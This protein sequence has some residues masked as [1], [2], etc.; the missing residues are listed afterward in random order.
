[1]PTRWLEKCCGGLL[2]WGHFFL[3]GGGGGGG[4][5][6][7]GISISCI[8]LGPKGVPMWLLRDLSLYYIDTLTG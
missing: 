1:M 4:T 7:Y 8:Y 2:A 3:G 5:V 6:V